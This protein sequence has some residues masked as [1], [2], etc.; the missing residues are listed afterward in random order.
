L[1]REIVLLC[2]G[3]TF[4]FGVF[5]FSELSSLSVLIYCCGTDPEN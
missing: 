4:G 5:V 1:R 2:A 3:C